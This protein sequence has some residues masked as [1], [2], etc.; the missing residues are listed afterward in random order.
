MLSTLEWRENFE[1]K[2]SAGRKIGNSD[3]LMHN[4]NDQPSLFG[5]SQ[6]YT[7]R[8]VNTTLVLAVFPK[9]F[10]GQRPQDHILPST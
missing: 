8:N 6:A 2:K 1:K 5:T 10:I 9:S 4:R 3:A 7:I